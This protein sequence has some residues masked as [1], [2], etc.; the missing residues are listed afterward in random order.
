[1]AAF[2]QGWADGLYGHAKKDGMSKAYY[3]AYESG[4]EEREIYD[5]MDTAITDGL[6]DEERQYLYGNEGD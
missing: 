4:S 6:N 2:N 1:M 5:A 3:R